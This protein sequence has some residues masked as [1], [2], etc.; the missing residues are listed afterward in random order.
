MKHSVRFLPSHGQKKVS[1]HGQP[2]FTGP[3]MFD[4]ASLKR[5]IIPLV[6]EQIL[7]VT[8]GMADIIMVSQVGPAAPS[9]RPNI[10]AK[11]VARMPAGPPINWCC[12]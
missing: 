1:G 10:W 4:N 12:P 8:V 2:A 7:A 6:I 9:S 5:L 3:G 11:T